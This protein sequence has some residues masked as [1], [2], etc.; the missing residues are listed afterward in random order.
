MRTRLLFK[1]EYYVMPMAKSKQTRREHYIFGRPFRDEVIIQKWT[2]RQIRQPEDR[3]PQRVT[4]SFYVGPLCRVISYKLTYFLKKHTVYFFH[5]KLIWSCL[6]ITDTSNS[7]LKCIDKMWNRNINC[8]LPVLKI[9]TS[10]FDYFL[11]DRIFLRCFNLRDVRENH[12]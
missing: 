12:R 8:S 1:L 9:K 11:I 7:F 5:W 10:V 6:A 4:V 2:S 3:N